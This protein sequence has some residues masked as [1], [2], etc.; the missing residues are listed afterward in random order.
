VASLGTLP[1]L[2]LR[3]R[4]PTQVGRKHY[5]EQ[6][7]HYD[8]NESGPIHDALPLCW[9]WH[10][11][12]CPPCVKTSKFVPLPRLTKGSTLY[13]VKELSSP[14]SSRHHDI[15]HFVFYRFIFMKW[16]LAVIPQEQR[17]GMNVAGGLKPT[18]F[19]TTDGHC[20][21]SRTSL[22]RHR[23]KHGQAN[24]LPAKPIPYRSP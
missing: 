23:P 22:C 13:I 2:P 7:L 16:H 15:Y 1:G 17:P 11:L 14:I 9:C 3:G 5:I 8:S 24:T 18:V 20:N 12:P 19:P 21:D 4:R 6:R 10:L